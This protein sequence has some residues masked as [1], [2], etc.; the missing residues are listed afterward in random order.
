MKE[1][2]IQELGAGRIKMNEPLS[3]HVYMKVGGPADFYYEAQNAKELEMVVHL[4]IKEKIPCTLIGNGANVLVSDKGVRGLVVQNQSKNIKF[5]PYNFVEV[6]SGVDNADLI[7]A[8][9]NR[10]LTGMERLLKVPGTIGGAIYMNAGD[11]GRKDFFGDLVTW[12]EVINTKGDTKKLRKEDC[13][14]SYRSSRFQARDATA[15]RGTLPKRCCT[16]QVR[17][18]DTKKKR[19]RALGR[20]YFER[21]NIRWRTIGPRPRV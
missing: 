21:H 6:D 11:T 14:F 2:L 10:S 5:L 16:S 7:L 13:D 19:R 8:A 1:K 17:T 15:L 20:F 18:Q 12:V 3:A 9:K 4:A